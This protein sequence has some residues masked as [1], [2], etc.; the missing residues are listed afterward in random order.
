MKIKQFKSVDGIGLDISQS[1]LI[2]LKGEPVRVEVNSVGLTECDYEN[3][4]FRFDSNDDL[5]E[6]TVNALTLEIDGEAIQFDELLD[7][8]KAND[9]EFFERYGFIVSPKFGVAFDPE[10]PCWVTVL[11]KVGLIG[12][13]EI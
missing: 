8:I 7:F 4:I 1:E 3:S 9:H 11:A 5:N 2:K 12:W 13:Q 10:F 6:L